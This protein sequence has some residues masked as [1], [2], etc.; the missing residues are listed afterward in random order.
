M[1]KVNKFIFLLATLAFFVVA[2]PVH[3]FAITPVRMLLTI[4]PGATQTAVVKIFNSEKIDLTFKLSVLGVEQNEAGEP[5]F[6]R[7]VEEAE[8]WV[9]PED[10]M[11]KI[12]SGETKSVNFIIKTPQDA[13]PGSHYV[14]FAVE[15]LIA[16][17]GGLNSRLISLVTMQVTGVVNESL[18]IEKWEKIDIADEHNWKFNLTL[19]NNGTVE[20]PLKQGVISIKNWRG[21][22]IVSEPIVLGNKLLVGSQRVLAPITALNNALSLPGLYQASV[23]IKYGITNQTVSAISYIWYFPQWSKI[24]AVVLAAALVLLLGFALFRKRK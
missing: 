15:P 3:A 19:Q 2:Q 1:S 24:T 7:G 4:D 12:K 20:V 14:G 5:I 17:Q 22:E 6:G 10:N 21:E 23:M 13:S 16:T 8:N 18:I 9:Y 11:V